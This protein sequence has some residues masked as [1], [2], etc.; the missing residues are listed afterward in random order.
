MSPAKY[1]TRE[2]KEAMVDAVR[3][4]EKNTSGEIRIHV[5]NRAPE[6]VLDRAAKVFAELN[7]HKTAL[8][9]G[10][11]IYVA[12]ENHRL[13]ILGDAGIH[14]RVPAGYWD[15]IKDRMVEQF[16]AGE[17]CRGICDAVTAVGEQLK[18][19]FP[20]RADDTNELPDDISFGS[21]N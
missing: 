13:A 1:F 19:L 5:E 15:H 3:R 6:E 12:L 16:K 20:Y 14:T 7:M 17:V 4:A 8:R 10:V 9:N 21:D 11:L 2:E 18:T